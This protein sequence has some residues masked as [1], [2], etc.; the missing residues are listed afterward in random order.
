MNALKWAMILHNNNLISTI[1]LYDR[2]VVPIH[3]MMMTL[4]TWQWTEYVL[5]NDY[6]LWS[7]DST[8]GC[9]KIWTKPSSLSVFGKQ[10]DLLH[11]VFYS[12]SA[13][14]M[15]SYAVWPVSPHEDLPRH[16]RPAHLS[17]P[18]H[19]RHWSRRREGETDVEEIVGIHQKLLQPRAAPLC[20]C[21]RR[22]FLWPDLILLSHVSLTKSSHTHFFLGRDL[23]L[24]PSSTDYIWYF[25]WSASWAATSGAFIWRLQSR[26]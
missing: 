2:V 22:S 8:D 24:I 23:V 26:P 3:C 20:R 7:V 11:A 5:G 19:T 17:D 6:F 16:I 18:A 12:R 4:C 14:D 15:R 9:W 1:A 13:S 10:S 25:Q 21:G